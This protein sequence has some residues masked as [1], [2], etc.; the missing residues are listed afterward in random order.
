M[1]HGVVVSNDDGERSA[2]KS[3]HPFNPLGSDQ[4]TVLWRE[5]YYG[6]N[7]QIRGK[8]LNHEG[9]AS[10]LGI[11]RAQMRLLAVEP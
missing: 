8:S 11:L 5:S 7:L 10:K 9:I 2:Q 4:L 1:R 6:R 3:K